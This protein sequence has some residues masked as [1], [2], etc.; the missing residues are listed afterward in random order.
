LLKNVNQNQRVVVGG[1][2]GSRKSG[3][4]TACQGGQTLDVTEY[5][6]T[7]NSRN[8]FFTYTVRPDAVPM[9]DFDLMVNHTVSF[10]S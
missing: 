10:S 8:Y 7:T 9:S 4:L 2:T 3:T 6:F 1:V 5:D